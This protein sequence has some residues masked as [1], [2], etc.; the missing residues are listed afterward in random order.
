MNKTDDED[1]NSPSY[2]TGPVTPGSMP[3]RRVTGRG[4]TK[5]ASTHRPCEPFY[6]KAPQVETCHETSLNPS[7]FEKSAGLSSETRPSNMSTAHTQQSAPD[8]STKKATK[9]LF[10]ERRGHVFEAEKM[11]LEKADFRAVAEQRFP[12]DAIRVQE[13]CSVS[14]RPSDEDKEAIARRRLQN[15][16][17]AADG[18]EEAG[19]GIEVA[20]AAQ[21]EKKEKEYLC[22]L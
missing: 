18:Q 6:F 15:V 16:D 2:R 14:R 4:L 9:D 21:Y 22:D 3:T 1:N 20:E 5:P 19:T 17:M 8:K 12:N 7:S 11:G 13:Y 10:G